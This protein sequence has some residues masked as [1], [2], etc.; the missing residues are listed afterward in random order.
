MTREEALKIWL[1]VI[2]LGVEHLSECKVALDMA[3]EA[4]EQEPCDVSDINVGEIV[5]NLSRECGGKYKDCVDCVLD[6]IRA[7]IKDNRDEW[8]EGQDTEW[9]IYDRCLRIIDKYKLESEVSE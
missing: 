5:E 7:T 2:R 6:K 3:I 9:N 4:L 1:P 8:I